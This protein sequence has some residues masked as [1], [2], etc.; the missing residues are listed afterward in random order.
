MTSLRNSE[1]RYGV[2]PML[3]HW[4]MALLIIGLAALGLYMV[5]LP[6]AGYDREKITLIVVHKAFGMLALALV[7]LRLAWRLVDMLPR[8]VEGAP[9]WQQVAAHVMHLLLYALML[10]VP[11]TG[12]IMSSMGGYPLSF[13]GWFEVPDVVAENEALFPFFIELHA[14]LAWTLVAL[15]AVHV[16]AAL[17]HHFVIRDASLRRMLP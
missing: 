9:I 2:L 4:G 8:G 14:W 3:L 16:V 13:F 17:R 12:W 5:S 1:S 6:D 7:A 10:A 11:L 15:V